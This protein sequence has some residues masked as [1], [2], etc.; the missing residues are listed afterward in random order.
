MVNHLEPLFCSVDDF[1]QSFEIEWK[2]QLLESGEVKRER[3]VQ[4]CLG[5]ILTIL[6]DFHHSGFRN[7]KGYFEFL[8]QYRKRDFPHLISYARFVRL[9]PR[10]LIPTVP[11]NVTDSSC[12]SDYPS[13]NEQPL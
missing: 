10:A 13:C 9:M 5:E 8:E 3:P 2:K 12:R 4:L 11:A 6:I 1:C 7:F